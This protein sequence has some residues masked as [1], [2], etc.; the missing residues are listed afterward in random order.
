M[1]I[2]S[3]YFSGFAFVE[4][5]DKR[6]AEDAIK[7]LDGQEIAGRRIAVEWAKGDRKS[8]GQF[9]ILFAA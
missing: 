9:L 4:Y 3:L 5:Q 6:D 8:S 2:N 7:E 1:F